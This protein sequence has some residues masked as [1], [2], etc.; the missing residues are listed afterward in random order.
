[1]AD[2]QAAMR[3]GATAPRPAPKPGR[4]RA[5]N[6]LGMFA[7]H[8]ALAKAYFTFNGHILWASSIDARH[9][10]LVILRVGAV[11]RAEYEFAQHVYLGQDAGL[12][13]AE[14]E[15][16]I[17][18]PQAE[19]WSPLE[20]ALLSA[21]DELIADARIEDATWATLAETYDTQQLMDLVFTI[22]AYELLA[23]AFRTF[24]VP[25]DEDLKHTTPRL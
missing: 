15:R 1:M 13:V 7:N 9:R 12:T 18:G 20:A 2:A 22:G 23:M 25:M 24:D 11:R 10:E 3:A 8:P 17:E 21:V 5:Q 14:I 6:V 16:I 4:P 19:G